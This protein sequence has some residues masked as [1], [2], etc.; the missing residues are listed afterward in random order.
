MSHPGLFRGVDRAAFAAGLA[1]RLRG[2]GVA[3]GVSG[4][5]AFAAALVAVPDAVGD[6]HRLYWLA[7]VTL[8]SRHDDLAAFDA[9]FEAVFRVGGVRRDPHA[10]RDHA[11]GRAPAG[12]RRSPAG[13]G[14]ATAGAAGGTAALPWITRGAADG[15]T[16]RRRG[17]APQYAASAWRAL[18]TTPFEVLDPAGLAALGDRLEAAFARR[19]TRRSRRTDEHPRGRPRAAARHARPDAGAT[20][21]S[22]STSSPA[23]RARVPRRLVVLVDVS[24]SMQPLR[25][26]VPA[27]GAGRRPVGGRRG[28]RVLPHP[29][30]AHAGARPARRGGGAGARDRRASPTGSAARGSRPASAASSPTGT[31]AGAAAPSSS[32]RPTAGT[33]TTRPCW[34]TRWP[35]CAAGAPGR[36]GEPAGRG[37]RVRAAGRR[38]GRRAAALR[39]AAARTHAGGRRRRRGRAGDDGPRAQL[40]SVTWTARRKCPAPT[41]A[42]R[43]ASPGS[44]AASARSG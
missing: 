28:V 9:V 27:P 41:P 37:V 22:R 33:A 19:P 32:S 36:L 8:V 39:R 10:R 30:P 21:A 44:P 4:V 25:H 42:P 35:G 34:A 17:T 14:A 24:R 40:Q 6:R 15:D 38:D 2:A 31:P 1:A 16:R 23:G 11:A 5:E 43:A 12:P 13:D 3:V 26:R 20:A 7:R 18:A 29:H